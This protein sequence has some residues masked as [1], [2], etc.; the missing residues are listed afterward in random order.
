MNFDGED[1]VWTVTVTGCEA[2]EG[3]DAYIAEAAFDV[4]P[5]REIFSVQLG[6][7][8]G[9]T[10]NDE[11]VW[12]SSS[13]ME[14]VQKESSTTVPSMALTVSSVTTFTFGDTVGAPLSEGQTW[15][16]TQTVTPSMGNPMISD[17][18]VAVSAA[19]EITVPAGTYNCY[20]VVHTS[21][22]GVKTEYWSI[23]GDLLTPVKVVDGAAFTSTETRE[24][25]SYAPAS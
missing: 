12:R 22:D 7:A 14:T 10:F 21:S 24:L 19:E 5:N 1:T 23:D 18:T 16:Y 4:T 25:A 9:V 15:S 13:N 8:L 20:P 6:S 2:V 11:S 3:E 17:W